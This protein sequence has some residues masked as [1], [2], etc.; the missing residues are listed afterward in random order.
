MRSG[1]FQN[2]SSGRHWGNHGGDSRNHGRGCYPGYYPYSY[3]GFGYPYGFG[4]P[5]GYGFGYGYGYPYYGASAS[6]Y[7]NGYHP[8][9]RYASSQ[10]YASGGSVVSQ[11]QQRLARAGYYRGRIDGIIGGGTRGAIRAWE[12]AHGLRVDGQIDDRLLSTMDLA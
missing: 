6:L 8:Y 4:Y 2:G 5:F 3:S 11:V 12:R 10:S 9:R 1:G 7:Y